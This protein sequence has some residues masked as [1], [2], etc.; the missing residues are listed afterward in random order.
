MVGMTELK[1]SGKRLID[2]KVKSFDG[3]DVGKVKSI[4]PEIVE[5][6]DGDKRYFVPKLHF[7]EHD[8]DLY[9]LL[10]EDEVRDKYQRKDPPLPSEIQDAVRSGEGYNSYHQIIPFM[11]KEPDLELKGEKSGDILKIPW[12]EVI[13]KH[14]RTLDNVDIGDVDRVG[15]EFIVVREGVANVHLYYIPKQ[16]I[17]NY[18]GSSIWIDV[19]SGLVSPK[20]EREDEPTQEEIDMLLSEVPE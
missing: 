8:K 11:A 14:V 9:V 3:K 7:K 5:L 17:N 20:F 2:K 16:Y 10:M 12:D 15:N 13:H 1:I 4:T 6:K 18:D 19:A